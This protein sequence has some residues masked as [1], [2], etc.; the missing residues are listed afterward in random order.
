MLK[1]IINVKGFD[2]I[3]N[4]GDKV[5]GIVIKN[6]TDY[7]MILRPPKFPNGLVGISSKTI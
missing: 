6:K 7:E 1:M 4:E 3:I 5:V 2:Y